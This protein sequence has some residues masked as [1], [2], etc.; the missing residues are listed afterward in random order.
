M[1]DHA[2]TTHNRDS[3]SPFTTKVTH[4]LVERLRRITP[5]RDPQ[6]IDVD[7]NI[8]MYSG[9]IHHLFTASSST[10]GDLILEVLNDARKHVL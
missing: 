8:H 9:K 5:Q 3:M 4:E 6:D 7:V 10:S 2:V 1:E